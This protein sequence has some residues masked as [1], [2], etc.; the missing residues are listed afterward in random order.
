MM[1][2]NR[3]KSEFPLQLSSKT[4]FYRIADRYRGEQNSVKAT[5]AQSCELVVWIISTGCVERKIEG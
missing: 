2:Q 3:R 4:V 1:P 5:G